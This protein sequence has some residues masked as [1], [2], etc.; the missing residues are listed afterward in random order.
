MV[1]GQRISLRLA[2]ADAFPPISSKGFFAEISIPDL[3]IVFL[4]RAEANILP[5][6]AIRTEQLKSFL[7]K[8]VLTKPQIETMTT[9]ANHNTS[10]VG[11]IIIDMVYSEESRIGLTAYST[12]ASI[13]SKDFITKLVST[14]FIVVIATPTNAA[15]LSRTS[16]ALTTLACLNFFDGTLVAMFILTIK[17]FSVF[18]RRLRVVSI[19]LLLKSLLAMSNIIIMAAGLAGRPQTIL[20]T[21]LLTKEISR[22]PL[23]T[24]RAVLHVEVLLF[25]FVA[26]ITKAIAYSNVDMTSD[27]K[28]RMLP[29]RLITKLVS[30]LFTLVMARLT[31]VADLSRISKALTTHTCLSLP[32]RTFA[33]IL[34]ITGLDF[35]LLFRRSRRGN[36]TVFLHNLFTAIRTNTRIT[37]RVTDAG[38][39]LLWLVLLVKVVK[40]KPALTPMT[41]YR[42][43]V[44]LLPFETL[45]TKAIKYSSTGMASNTGMR[46][47]GNVCLMHTRCTVVMQTIRTTFVL[48]PVLK[49]RR[50]PLVAFHTLSLLWKGCRIGVI[51]VHCCI[52]ITP[53]RFT[54]AAKTIHMSFVSLP[55][56]RSCWEP[57]M[58]HRTTLLLQK[59]CRIDML[60]AHCR[61]SLIPLVSTCFT[62]AIQPI[63]P[64]FVPVPVLSGSRKPLLTSW[65]KF[66]FLRRNRIDLKNNIINRLIA[67][68]I[69]IKRALNEVFRDTIMHGGRFLSV[70]MTRDVRCVIKAT[71]C[72]IPLLCHGSASI[73]ANMHKGTIHLA[74]VAL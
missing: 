51:R 42:I 23:L 67:E 41:I 5:P 71:L 28:T 7:G 72:C 65:T 38:S 55:V 62:V 15:N 31:K 73:P 36:S 68:S 18:I 24:T 64:G 32:G 63:L 12:G 58:A 47:P 13:Y 37:A 43:R 56:L 6:I 10:M 46:V 25:P 14:L 16:K 30:L 29:N 54:A 17:Q 74:E 19:I 9:A 27:A 70:I 50:E 4:T 3:D 57:L 61:I 52:L 21:T 35:T 45:I 66:L 39:S 59:R 48:M 33:L 22:K 1:N 53:T 8:T 34:V 49:S 44:H 26:L 11:T 40:R 20:G 69:E 60:R 2:A